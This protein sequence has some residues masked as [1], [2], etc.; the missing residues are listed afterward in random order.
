[1]TIIFVKILPTQDWRNFFFIISLL[2][3]VNILLILFLILFVGRRFVTLLELEEDLLKI[4]YLDFNESKSIVIRRE[5]LTHR[6]YIGSW[7]FKYKG[8]D[9]LENDK[10]VMNQLSYAK[11]SISQMKEITKFLQNEG[12][13]KPFGENL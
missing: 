1:M 5:D 6:L 8:F 4:D 9:F 7:W 2:L 3:S 11:W 10:V 12:I 13:K